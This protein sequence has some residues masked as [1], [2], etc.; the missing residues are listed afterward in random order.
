M[1]APT[2]ADAQSAKERGFLHALYGGL[3]V[4]PYGLYLTDNRTRNADRY[5]WFEGYDAGLQW[6]S[7]V[8][9]LYWEGLVRLRTGE[10]VS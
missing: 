7:R 9:E 5:E 8:N 10:L 2:Y 3:R 6:E 1:I 4:N